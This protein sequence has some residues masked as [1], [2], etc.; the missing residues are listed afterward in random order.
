MVGG[1][2]IDYP[3]DVSN[4][5]ADTTMAKIVMNSTIS[6]PNVK[7][8]CADI[9]DF[10]LGMPME[11][12]EYVCIPIALILP[13]IIKENSRLT[14][15]HNAQR[16]CLYGNTPQYVW[17]TPQTGHSGKPLVVVLLC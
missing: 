3:C 5:M 8:M 9:K 2:L 15:V 13:E 11:C 10:Y 14:L 17:T 16:A 4:P 7:F 12:Y 6:I 1:N